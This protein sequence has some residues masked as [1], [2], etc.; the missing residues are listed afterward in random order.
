MNTPCT[1]CSLS[2]SE[3]AFRQKYPTSTKMEEAFCPGLWSYTLK[4]PERA[5]TA[6]CPR[7]GQL[8]RIYGGDAATHWLQV[9][10]VGLYIKSPCKDQSVVDGIKDFA[11][12]E[13]VVMM[14]YKLTELML[15]FAGYVVG[16]YGASNWSAFD[17]RR[18]CVAFKEEFLPK[19]HQALDAIKRAQDDKLREEK[20]AKDKASAVSWEQFHLSKP[21]LEGLAPYCKPIRQ[22][23]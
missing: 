15:F 22:P 19:R 2:P 18:I 6:K 1:P 3:V 12:I 20:S 7:L 5:L 11:S 10:F 14:S 4:K 23:A 16:A 9:Q 17:I 13:C 21:T 8:D